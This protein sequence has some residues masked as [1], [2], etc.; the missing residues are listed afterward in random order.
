[1]LDFSFPAG[2]TSFSEFFIKVQP[3]LLFVAAIVIY[4]FFVYK[5]YRFLSKRDILVLKL[6]NKPTNK[7]F[8]L[9]IIYILKMII[10]TP[11]ILGYPSPSLK[12]KAHN[13]R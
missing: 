12:I 3:L 6:E 9:K 5:F 13:P 10:F 7:H 1:M 2:S 11:I 4:S 8:S